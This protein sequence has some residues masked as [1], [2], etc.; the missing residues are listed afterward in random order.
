MN[1]SNYKIGEILLFIEFNY[2]ILYQ[3]IVLNEIL[4]IYT[5][6]VKIVSV[7][8]QYIYVDLY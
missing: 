2:F 6:C 5:V 7:P 1:L 8:V 4:V 3:R